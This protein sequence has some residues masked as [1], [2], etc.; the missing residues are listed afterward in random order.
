M[1]ENTIVVPPEKFSQM[2]CSEIEKLMRENKHYSITGISLGVDRCIIKPNNEYYYENP[3]NCC[4]RY[5]QTLEH[6]Q[7]QAK[8]EIREIVFEMSCLILIKKYDDVIACIVY[9]HKSKNSC[10]ILQY[11]STPKITLSKSGIINID[12]YQKR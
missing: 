9:G 2:E 11:L 8:A 3:Y 1:I 4:M 12:T 6:A 10:K 7:K 5:F